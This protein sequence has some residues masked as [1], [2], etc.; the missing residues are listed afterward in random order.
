METPLES[1]FL[2]S[3]FE[4]RL[5]EVNAKYNQ[6]YSRYKSL[7]SVLAYYR[8]EAIPLADEQI[9]ASN[10][11]YRLGNIDY[12]QFIQ[13]IESALNTK[14]KYLV[15]QAEYSEIETELKYIIGK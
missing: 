11:A 10:L 3:Q 7:Q 9:A 8:D 5:L 4:Q 1:R 14:R 15:Q 12:I 6:L 13:N 2:F